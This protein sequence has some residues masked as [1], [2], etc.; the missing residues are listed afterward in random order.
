MNAR[1]FFLNHN[2]INIGLVQEEKEYLKINNIDH[3]FEFSNTFCKKNSR[4]FLT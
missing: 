1:M 3:L 4:G 2:E